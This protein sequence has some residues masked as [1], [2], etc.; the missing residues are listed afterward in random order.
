MRNYLNPDVTVRSRG[1]MEKCTFCI[2]RLRR[3]ELA[4]ESRDGRLL[5]DVE[6]RKGNYL[7]ACVQACPSNALAFGEQREPTSPVYKYFQDVEEHKHESERTT[8][9]YKLLQEIGTDPNVVYLKKFDLF[10]LK[11]D[12]GH[13]P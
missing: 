4:V 5:D 10:P 3:G 1:I 12:T 8:R 7:P 6:L 13:G 2:H 11:K 9:A